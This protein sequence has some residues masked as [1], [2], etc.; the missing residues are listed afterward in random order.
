MTCPVSALHL[1]CSFPDTFLQSPLKF[2]RMCKIA[3]AGDL[4]GTLA[5]EMTGESRAA[6][7]SLVT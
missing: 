3:S 5:S 4:Q 2:S 6:C 1:S 7:Q